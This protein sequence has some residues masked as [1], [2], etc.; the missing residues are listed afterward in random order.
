MTEELLKQ[1]RDEVTIKKTNNE[2]QNTKVQRIKELED[3]PNVREYIYLIGLSKFN[4]LFNYEDDDQ[5]VSSIYNKYIYL[6]QEDETNGIYVYLGTFRYSDEIDIVHSSCDI[7]V[8]YDDKRADYRL[9]KNIEQ[10]F[11]KKININDCKSFE[12]ENIILNPNSYYKEKEYY[13]IQKEFFITAVKKGQEAARRRILKKYP[14][15]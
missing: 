15:L 13:N 10:V 9:Y 5:I 4:T 3:D 14:E 2:K 7:R 12:R 11:A 1:L 8:K 6:I